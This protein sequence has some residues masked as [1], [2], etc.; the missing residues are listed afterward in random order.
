MTPTDAIPL[1]AAAQ[2]FLGIMAFFLALVVILVGI[3]LE[4]KL[5]GPGPIHYDG[6]RLRGAVNGRP[7][8]VEALVLGFLMV[9]GL[10]VG[11]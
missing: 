7:V 2:M 5:N 10:A 9:V 6:E 3:R 1:Y 4:M 8:P 11:G